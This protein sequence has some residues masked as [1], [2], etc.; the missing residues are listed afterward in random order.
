[1]I[2]KKKLKE[3]YKS[4]V[5]SKGVFVIRNKENGRVFLGSSLNL[6]N[7]FERIKLQL[8]GGTHPNSS[9]QDDWT[10]L[11]EDAFEY[12]ILELL[13][14]KDD[15]NYNYSDD[16]ELIELLWIEKFQPFSEKCYNKNE[17]IRMV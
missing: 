1:M 14:I 17:K 6:K 2:D 16:L 4:I 9:F 7:K 10:K 12:E 3:E 5:Q 15:I 13:E 11:K 8:N